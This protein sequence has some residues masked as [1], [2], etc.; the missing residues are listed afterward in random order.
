M[1]LGRDAF[2]EVLDL[3]AEPALALLQAG[4]AVVTSTE[5]AAEGIRAFKE[6]RSP[7]WSGR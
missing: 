5:D 7:V 1:K 6:K 2:Y 3:A 4:L